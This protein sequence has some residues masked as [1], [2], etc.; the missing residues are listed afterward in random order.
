ML[1]GGN[2]LA[3]AADLCSGEIRVIFFSI[4]VVNG[5]DNYADRKGFFPT[6]YRLDE[7]NSGK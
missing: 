6:T 5:D 2:N 1:Y 7:K 4:S 3:S